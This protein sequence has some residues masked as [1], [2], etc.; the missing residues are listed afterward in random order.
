MSAIK[1]NTTVAAPRDKV[2]AT[3]SDFPNAAN[4][5]SA[6]DSIEMLTEGPVA[7][8]TQFRE[9][10][11]LFGRQATETMEVTRFEPDQQYTLS[12]VSCGC[13]FDSHFHFTDA[14]PNRTEVHVEMESRPLT[15]AARLMTPL[16]W[17]M[18]GT[19]KKCLQEDL[20]QVKALCEQNG[21]PS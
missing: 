16:G 1:L 10:R 17:L 13:Q 21:N 8:G 14:G 20:A 9:T 18:K 19:M 15:M 5:I 2:F 12:A 4:Y 6:I 7:V 11:T 3:Y